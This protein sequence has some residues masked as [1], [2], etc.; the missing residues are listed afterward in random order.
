MLRF[1]NYNI[2]F[3]EIP[4]E[5]TLAINIS[6]CPNGCKG[7]HSSYL[8][9][10]IGEVLNEE[11]LSVLINKYSSAITCVCFMGGDADPAEVERLAIFLRKK[12]MYNLK[13]GWYSGKN[14]FP[15]KCSV[16]NFD[17]LKLGAYIEKLGGL[18]CKT[19]NQR[20]YRV[21]DGIMNDITYH[22][23][24]HAISI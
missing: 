5:V 24:K 9:Q 20:L 14:T 22:F 18:N 15:A 2:V 3:Q 8:M 16:Q 10:D 6:N 19:T 11:A 21:E 23:Q 7:C 12:I 4:D 17:Y 13:V 1:T